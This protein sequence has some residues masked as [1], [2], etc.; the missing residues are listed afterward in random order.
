MTLHPSLL[1]RALVGGVAALVL[2]AVPLLSRSADAVIH[3]GDQLAIA[4]Y[5][6]PSLSQTT[7]VQPDGTI[8]YPLVGRISL[9]G[10]TASEAHDLLTG[11]IGRYVKR[12]L[13]T[14]NVAQAGQTNVL[15]L[16]N[17]K[18]PGKYQ[19]RSGARLTDAIASA[20]GVA[21]INGDYPAARVSQSDGTILTAS[22][23]DLLHGGDATQNLLLGENAIVYVVGAETINVH[24]LGAVTHPGLVSI[25]RGDRLTMALA[26]AGAE[27][28]ARPDLN[29]VYITRQNPA[30]GKA[31]SSVVNL[32]E[33][34]QHGDLRSDPV[35][36][37]DDTVYVSE[38]RQPNPYSL[39]VFSFLGNLIR[40]Y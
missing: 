25:N 38:T 36:Q 12:P 40:L 10:K 7:V 32:Y 14:V 17:V 11:A 35:L 33:A 39:G 28:Q 15:V 9:A 22:L 4:V 30:T 1:S 6:D 5:G 26:R 20:S 3:P 18:N 8:Q 13:L 23:Q 2:A 24:V 16:G 29:H 34:V 21:I 19:V 37:K 27:S 31:D